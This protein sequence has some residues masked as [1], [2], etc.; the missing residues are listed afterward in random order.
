MASTEFVSNLRGRQI[1]GLTLWDADDALID[2]ARLVLGV[3]IGAGSAT[4][5]AELNRTD[6]LP[7]ADY[8]AWA[9][10]RTVRG[11]TDDTIGETTETSDDIL[12]TIKGKAPW[13]PLHVGPLTL[14]ARLNPGATTIKGGMGAGRSAPKGSDRCGPAQLR[15]SPDT[16]RLTFT[17][18][19]FLN[20]LT[21]RAS[22]R[23]PA[24]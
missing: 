23:P 20:H 7:S 6:P 5:F 11:V 14:V 8:L 18:S 13:R 17:R 19:L 9:S 10:N 4:H 21:P 15:P 3:P 12:A 22:F 24:P 1:L 16:C 2:Q